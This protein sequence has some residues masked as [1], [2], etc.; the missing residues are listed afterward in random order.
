VLKVGAQD[1]AN[2]W[3]GMRAAVDGNLLERRM[4]A[5]NQR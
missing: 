5:K 3:A 1:V 4:K 2:F